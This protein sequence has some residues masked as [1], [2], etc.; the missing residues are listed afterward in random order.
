MK[1][2]PDWAKSALSVLLGGAGRYIEGLGRFSPARL[3]AGWGSTSTTLF[4][5]KVVR[6]MLA[7]SGRDDVG[8]TSAD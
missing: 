7:S 6:N 2:G 8:H 5:P 4:D 1:N 3:T